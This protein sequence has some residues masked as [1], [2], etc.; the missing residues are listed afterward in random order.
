M[1]IFLTSFPVVF[2]SSKAENTIIA[3]IYDDL[4]IK[5]YSIHLYTH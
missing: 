5:T 3:V 2:G 4:F 1:I